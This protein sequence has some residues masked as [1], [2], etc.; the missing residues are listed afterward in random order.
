MQYLSFLSSPRVLN[1][2]PFHKVF[3]EPAKNIN[4]IYF[5]NTL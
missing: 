1:E 3:N 4:T 5:K 2:D